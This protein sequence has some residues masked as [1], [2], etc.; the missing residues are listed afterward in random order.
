MLAALTG[1]TG[2]WRDQL[3]QSQVGAPDEGGLDLAGET[4]SHRAFAQHLLS[5]P[6]IA[7]FKGM[8]SLLQGLAPQ[9][10]LFHSEADFQHAL[11]RE[12]APPS[13]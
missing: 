1:S 3:S 2:E 12:L 10:P 4:E 6:R 8:I 7:E 5:D 13:S 9:R 11:G